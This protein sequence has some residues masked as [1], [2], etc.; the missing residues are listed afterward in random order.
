MVLGKTNIS[1]TS[2]EQ[3]RRD[4]PEKDATE[5]FSKMIKS[6]GDAIS[7][8]FDD[9]ELKKKAKEL[10]EAAKGSAKSFASRFED[11]DVK[12]KFR[13]AGK[14]AEDFGKGVQERFKEKKP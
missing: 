13:E 9:P 10:G 5:Q 6:F 11:E 4:M 2:L 7:E 14:A 12:Q 1:N 3:R 8:I